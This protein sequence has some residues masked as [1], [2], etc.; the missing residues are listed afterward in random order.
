MGAVVA[1]E[2]L[3]VSSTYNK[4]ILNNFGEGEPWRTLL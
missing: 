3:G 4:E 2:A 1:N